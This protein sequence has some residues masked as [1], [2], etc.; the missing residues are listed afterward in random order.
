MAKATGGGVAWLAEGMPEFRRT[1]VS[2]DTAGQGWMGLRRNHSYV[3]T[4][5]AEISLLP[6]LIML[7]LVLGGLAGAW[8]RESR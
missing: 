3:V 5:L 8:W 1:G 6:G 7:A 4:G 2:R